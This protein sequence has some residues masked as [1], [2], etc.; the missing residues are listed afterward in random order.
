MG[1]LFGIFEINTP[2]RE[3]AQ[4][5]TQII[6]FLEESYYDQLENENL[7]VGQAFEKA[8]N[9]T[10]QKFT[11]LLKERQSYLV[12]NLNEL[13]IKE[14]INLAVGIL[15]ENK[16]YISYLNNIG[17]FL[18][19]RLKQNYKL[20]DIAQINPEE[21]NTE[22][23]NNSKIFMNLIEGEVNP[24][25][26]LF[27]A[28]SNFLEYVTPERIVKTV[29]SLPIHKAA[30]YFKNSL[31]QFEGHNF[32]AIIIRNTKVEL[33]ETKAH[34]SLTS[35]T[36]LNYTET[37]TE[38]LLSPSFWSN[39]V[40]FIKSILH[41]QGKDQALETQDIRTEPI[42][43][44]QN[45]SKISSGFKNIFFAIYLKIK[46]TFK[47]LL[48]KMPLLSENLQKLKNYLRLK[49]AYLGSYLKKIPNLSKIL[50]TVAILLIIL[51]I[52]STSYFHHQQ[53]Q[54]EQNKEFE[55]IISQIEDQKNQAE[56]SLIA[57]D[58]AKAKAAIIEAQKLLASLNIE[59][60][61]QR[62]EFQNLNK[63]LD[64]VIAKI[65]HITTI[66][67]PVLISEITDTNIDLRNLVYLN[68]N[69]YTFDSNNNYSYKINIDN[70]QVNKF[71][72]NLTDIGK[73]TKAHLV[74]AKI[75][76]YHN[77]NGFVEFKNNT[78]SPF[79]INLQAEGNLID[80]A[81]YT[82]KIY[83]LDEK[84]NQIYRHAQDETGYAAGLAWLKDK[85][86]D[87]KNM[88]AMGIDTNIWLLSKDGQIYKLNKGRKV[89][90][91]IKNLEP[92]LESP[93]ELFTDDG[94]NYLYIV[95]PKNKRI[96]VLDKEGNL[97]TQ[98]FSQSFDNLKALAINEKEKKLFVVNNNKILFTNLTHLK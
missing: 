56:S 93:T 89:N 84:T 45:K 67:E 79:A 87:L 44:S 42:R 90:F 60:Q 25:D 50:L 75:L 14:K 21:K 91:T 78:L 49:L 32:A 94:T 37:S 53:V 29:T 15:K 80:F 86:L 43:S 73:I 2:S 3:N 47:I 23:E 62:Q 97:V 85:T 63:G 98:Y 70:R 95:E 24:P 13:T 17:I 4:I 59:S 41:I 16:L 66:E 10:N 6:S 92:Q 8:L 11:Q 1:R 64:V 68:N 19:H 31:L 9:E 52:Y 55:N 18:I 48:E 34:P 96:V 30:E 27:L 72:S 22:A 69:L 58:E 5:I 77:R 7:N 51:F 28:N 26:Y 57:G 38:K 88:V 71:D 81:T 40:N 61:K 82:D 33:N 35:I 36:E 12:G 46:K 83:T 39:L 20:I 74:G 65:R 76:I 54:N